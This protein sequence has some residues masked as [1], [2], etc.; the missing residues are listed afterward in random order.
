VD[1]L[2]F[3]LESRSRVDLKKHGMYVYAEDASTDIL[4]FAF[5]TNDE[6]PFIWLPDKFKDK[7]TMPVC[8]KDQ[9]QWAIDN[10]DVIEAHNAGF[11]AIMWAEIMVKRYGFKP[12]PFDKLRCGAAKAASFA[13]PR[14]LGG[15]CKALG[16]EEQ[17]DSEGYRTM[18]KMCKPRKPTKN[19][20]AEWHETPEDFEKLCSYCIQDIN[21]ERALSKAIR[22][23]PDSELEVWRHD[24]IINNRGFRVDLDSIEALITRVERREKTLLKD[25]AALTFGKVTSVRQIAATLDFLKSEGVEL[26]KLTKDSVKEALKKDM[27]GGCRKLLEI[28]QK[29]GKAS[30]SK[31]M[32]MHRYA[33]KDSRVRGS[34]MYHGSAT[35]RYSGKGVQP[36]NYP[37]DSYGDKD[38]K[39]ILALDDDSLEMVYED[40]FPAASKCLR[41][42][43]VS[44]NRN[45]PFYCADYSSIEARVL[46]W[47]ANEDVALGAFRKGLDVYKV[48]ASEI[49]GVPYKEVDKDERQVGKCC[50]LALGYQGWLGAFQS[51]AQLY[52]VKIDD[53]KAKDIILKWRASR[54]NTVNLW[55]ALEAAAIKSVSEKT[56]VSYGKLKFGIRDNFLHMRLPSGRLLAYY[57]PKIQMI[58]PPHGEAKPAVTFM[59]TN[60]V[61]RKWERQST[62]GGKLA[63]NAT[64]AVARDLLVEAMLRVEK[65]GYPVV[66]HVHDEIIAE[67]KAGYGSLEEFIKI[68]AVV[69]SWASGC[70]IEADGWKGYR[71]RK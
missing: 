12:L 57:S 58:Q 53:E 65:A 21:A 48:N 35:G 55:A 63:E 67:P 11:E 9:F 15:A 47:L 33:C 24:Q 68:M 42:M 10:A 26:K 25:V 8:S 51:M 28:R 3:D 19:N 14:A 54:Q 30:V 2:T 71:Y 40:I 50:E 38:I 13:L 16:V 39:N 31:L 36:Q 46:A 52:G 66:L 34:I 37:R 70:P 17:K 44:P 45:T 56:V 20:S 59:S 61:T 27:P 18:L 43:I 69:P 22:P 41:G 1:E 60:S 49:Y 6:E 7:V 23:L 5:K 62:Y 4:C 32:S 29:L 64:Q